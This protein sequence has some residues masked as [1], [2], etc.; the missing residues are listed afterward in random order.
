MRTVAQMWVDDTMMAFRADQGPP[1]QSALLDQQV[2]FTGLLGIDIAGRK[3]QWAGPDGAPIRLASGEA[4]AARTGWTC[5][6]DPVAED[7]PIWDGAT[8]IPST[9]ELS[10]LG[11]E[12]G[13]ETPARCPKKLQGVRVATEAELSRLRGTRGHGNHGYQDG[14]D[15]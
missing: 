8:E 4:V 9:E 2:Y 11:T 1:A 5:A 12:I 10:Y 13:I 6:E 3:V 15:D 14:R 7:S